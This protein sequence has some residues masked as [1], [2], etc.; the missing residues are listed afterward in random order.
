MRAQ[1]GIVGQSYA[2]EDNLPHMRRRPVTRIPNLSL[3]EPRLYV[4]PGREP[5]DDV[6]HRL[7]L[8]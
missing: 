5:P 2:I 7:V 3:P 4:L 1:A 8:Q 6:K